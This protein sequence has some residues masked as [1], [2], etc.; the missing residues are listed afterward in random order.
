MII[1]KHGNSD[2][3]EANIIPFTCTR[4]GCEFKAT[5][6]ETNVTPKDTN[7]GSLF[8]AVLA[9]E[10]VDLIYKVDCPECG[11]ELIKDVPAEEAKEDND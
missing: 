9:Q 5:K 6:S 10:S 8:A 4:C 11:E 1:T 7:I 2:I 3:I